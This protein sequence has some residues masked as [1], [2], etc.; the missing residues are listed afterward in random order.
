MGQVINLSRTDA[1]PAYAM[2]TIFT[3]ELVKRMA[4]SNSVARTL[5]RLGCR[6]VDED[7]HPDDMGSPII[8]I[9]VDAVSQKTLPRALL[10]LSTCAVADA[11]A[12]IKRVTIEG[13]RVF[14]KVA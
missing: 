5:R 13:V 9:E 7:V 8:Q 12:G 10:H 1:L 6:I 3:P 2:P 11:H 14:W 4:I